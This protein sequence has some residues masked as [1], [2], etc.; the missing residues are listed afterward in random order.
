MKTDKDHQKTASPWPRIDAARVHALLGESAEFAFLDVR[1]EGLFNTGHPLTIVSAPFSH[2]E[3]R[4]AALVP[5]RATR[6]ILM[7]QQDDGLAERAARRLSGWGYTDISIMMDGLEGWRAA[8]LEVFAGIY[9]PSKA[10][11]EFVEHRYDTP[12]IDAQELRRW[13]EQGKDMII[14]D[15]R[16]YTEFHNYSLP[17]GID[18]PGAELVHRVFDLIEREETTIVVNCAG[19]T[20][21]II[22]AQSLINAGIK[23]PVVCVRNGTAGWHLAGETMARGSRTVAPPPSPKG[24]AA[25]IDAAMRV[26]QRFGVR[27]I[28]AKG[29][30]ALQADASRSLYFFD[31]RTPEEYEA[32]HIKGAR[33]APGGQLI[34]S[35]DHYVATRNS[36]IV[37]C[38]DNGVRA[39]MTASW[40]IQLGWTEVFVLTGGLVACGAA[41]DKGPESV[42]LLPMEAADGVERINVLDLHRL[43]AS[44][45]AVVVDL[46]NSLKFRVRHIPGAWFAVRSRLHDGLAQ[47]V[48]GAPRAKR[49]VLTSDDGAFA[50]LAAADAVAAS[51]LP[52]SILDGGTATWAAAGLPLASGLE[53]MTSAT[54][55]VWYSPYDYDDLAK[56]MT[57]YLTWEIDLIQQL[58]KDQSLQFRYFAPSA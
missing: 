53:N 34:Q 30:R 7:D 14:L 18:C 25:A 32:G 47:V 37:L 15:S 48:A 36:R 29:L 43:L 41:L 26:S 10:F 12:A 19:R 51:S 13:M 39:R 20:R 2:L 9:V 56:S 54:D 24:L 17:G 27:E 40:L 28:D 23:N 58:E 46:A 3:T 52:V 49:I 50:A 16:P 31:V 35:T 8:G 33:S 21:G 45:D 44:G 38:D 6:I 55:D 1:E 5:R 4:M 57:A 11:G 42:E 22:G